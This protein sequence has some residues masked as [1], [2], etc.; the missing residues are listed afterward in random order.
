MLGHLQARKPTHVA[1]EHFAID[2]DLDRLMTLRAVVNPA[3]TTVATWAAELIQTITSDL[4]DRLIPE[5]RVR[6]AAAARHRLR[7]SAHGLIQV[8]T[9]APAASGAFVTEGGPI[10]VGPFVFGATTLR[11]KKAANIVAI[12]DEMVFGSPADVEMTLQTILGESL[13]LMIDGVLLSSAA[14]TSAAP[15]GMLNGV[16]P[17]T[18]TTGGGPPHCSATSSNSPP[19]S[20]RP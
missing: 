1:R 8:P 10:P 15:A 5:S 3:N 11:G 14:A 12:N 6:P 7:A 2:R 4:A 16:T 20:R 9:W 18:A 17:L 13:G 19:R